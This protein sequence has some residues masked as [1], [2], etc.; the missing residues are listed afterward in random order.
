MGGTLLRSWVAQRLAP[1]A[2][3]ESAPSAELSSFVRRHHIKLFARMDDAVSASVA[4]CVVALKP[5]ILRQEAE[6]LAPVARSGALMVSIAAGTGLARLYKAWG[7]KAR[8][9]RAM[10]NTP[11]AIGRGITALYAR[12]SVKQPDRAHAEAL[13]G[14]LGSTLWV[15]R[16]A[17]ID[18][19]TAVSGSGPAYVFLFTECLA[20]AA[21]AQGLPSAL[22]ARLARATVSGAGALLDA[23]PRDPSALRRDVTSPGG[24]TQAALDVLMGEDVLARLIGRAVAAARLRATELRG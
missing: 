3:V 5:Q 6:R 21:E 23:D 17:H 7:S 4:V 11:G 20:R 14:G 2:V 9:I 22:A 12:P 1:L 8:I 19:V 24:T 15:G 10:P 16:E 13:L 18:T